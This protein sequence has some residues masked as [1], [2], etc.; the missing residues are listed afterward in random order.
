VPI[1]GYLARLLD[2]AFLLDNFVD[3]FP[4]MAT[5]PGLHPMTIDPQ[6]APLQHDQRLTDPRGI[7]INPHLPR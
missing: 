6:T 2:H 1:G 7:K 5:R 4:A 3:G